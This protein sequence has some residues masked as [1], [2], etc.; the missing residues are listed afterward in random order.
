MWKDYSL[1]YIK[2]NWASGISIMVAALISAFF[3]SF[4]CNLLY[5]SWTYEID[6]IILEEGDWQGRITGDIE[7]EDLQTIL[8]FANVE[9]CIVN[10][11]LSE[12]EKLVVDIYFY[13][14]K[15]IYQDMPLIVEKLGL[16]EEAVS[17]HTVLLSSYLIH[18]PEDKEPPLLLSFYLLILILVSFSLILI[19]R[20]SF[21]VT[22]GA[23]IHQFGILSGIGATPKQIRTC[24]MQEAA[25]LSVLPIFLGSLL[26]I[27]ACIGAMRMTNILAAGIE[28][29]HEATFNFPPLLFV[30]TI[31]VSLLTVLLS[32]WIPARKL[33]KLTPLEAIRGTDGRPLRRKSGPGIIARFFGVEGELAGTALKAQ[34]KTLRTTSISLT[35]SFLGFTL[36]LCALTLS[37]ISTR[38]TYFERYQNV[39]DEM[40]T[41]HNTKIEDFDRIGPL[42]ELES[43]ENLI[44]YQKAISY[45]VIS[46]EWLSDEVIELGGLDM[47]AGSAVSKN[48]DGWLVKAPLIIMDDQAF[49][50]YSREIGVTSQMD[51]VLILNQIWDSMNS[52]F[53]YKEYIPYMKENQDIVILQNGERSQ[54]KQEIPILGFTNQEPVLREEY[55]NY[56]L[57]QFLP[58][59]LWKKI[60]GQ[61]TEVEEDTYIRIL[62]KDRTTLEEFNEL[63][64]MIAGVLGAGY[65]VEMENRI[66]EK[67][68]NDNIIKAYKI[69]I[70]SFC[71]L[72]AIIGI[73]NVFSNTLGFIR[74]R[75][76]EFARY[77]SVG[78]TPGGMVKMFVVEAL[79]IAGRPLMI[80]LPVTVLAMIFMTK[81]SY[82]EWAEVLP[83]LHLLPMICFASIIFASVALAYYLG[84][85]RLLRCDLIE[86]LRNDT[87]I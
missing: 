46:E 18:D 5:S 48:Q 37:Q 21:A 36:M 65:Q 25:I 73:A 62:T 69:A 39:W 32:A 87:M 38:H 49:M 3:L 52:N 24:L 58:L 85:R 54:E 51:G 4:L 80:T 27:G 86:S 42:R 63:E 28:T 84:G 47:I 68:Y 44:V 45:A 13:N 19:I 9:K 75:R 76:R 16:E 10:K 66:E 30:A 35:L 20:N 41:L 57:V 81:L 83:E 1:S 60:S 29:R 17:Y 40:V 8:G 71:F 78:L 34:K 26:G 72:L 53:R 50:E 23:R 55:D 12:D 11:D 6:S 7:E 77:L 74:Q 70:A 82:L 59:S 79:V 64:D 33:S 67:I 2:N 43:V 22:M 15:R 31:M 61:I 56:S 14:M